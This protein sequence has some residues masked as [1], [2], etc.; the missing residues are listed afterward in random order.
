MP[1]TTSSHYSA[2]S[3]PVTVGA[4]FWDSNLRVVQITKVTSYANPYGSTGE[5]QTWHATTGGDCDT[6]SGSLRQ[7]GRLAR[8]FEGEDAGLFEPGTAFAF[9]YTS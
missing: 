2:D 1:D 3:Q 4:R 6:L 9:R 5:T 7:Y 8:Y